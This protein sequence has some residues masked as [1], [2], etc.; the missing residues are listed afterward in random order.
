MQVP[1]DEH[2]TLLKMF[3]TLL[4]PIMWKGRKGTNGEHINGLLD[5]L[6]AQFDGHDQ[7][8]ARRKVTLTK[9]ELLPSRW[10]ITSCCA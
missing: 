6:N 1:H 8:F 2:D 7:T 4:P 3:I 5:F 9:G 10:A